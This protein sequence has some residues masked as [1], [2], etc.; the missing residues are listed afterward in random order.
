VRSA[1]GPSD[2]AEQ[3]RAVV[4]AEAEIIRAI[5]P[6]LVLNDVHF[7]TPAAARAAGVP[8]VSILRCPYPTPGWRDAWGDVQLVPHAPRW[9]PLPAPGVRYCRPAWALRI[10]A[11]PEPVPPSAVAAA[12]C[13]ADA[14]PA[15]LRLVLDAFEHLTAEW[16]L[17]YPHPDDAAERSPRVVAWADVD[18]LLAGARVLV[19]HGGHGLIGRAIAR[20]VPVIVLETD[21][22]HTPIYGAA[23]EAAGAGV[24]LRRRDQTPRALREVTGRALEDT[25]LRAGAASLRRSLEALPDIADALA[26]ALEGRSCVPS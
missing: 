2:R 5:R 23:L 18:V 1:L 7:T 25:A 11:V 22:P 19:C 24:L 3:R 4:A 21:E 13:T 12:L 8:A 17:S 20:G 6:D 15:Q 10:G 26:A 16:V 9:L 14:Q